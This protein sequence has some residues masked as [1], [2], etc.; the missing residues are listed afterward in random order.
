MEVLSKPFKASALL[1]KIEA[2]MKKPEDPRLECYRLI[3]RASLARLLPPRSWLPWP[4]RHRIGDQRVNGAS[5]RYDPH[6]AW[7]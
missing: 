6:T 5:L 2:L 1:A 3:L 7:G 4:V